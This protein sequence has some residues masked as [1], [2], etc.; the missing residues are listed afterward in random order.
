MNA[1][2]TPE[3]CRALRDLVNHRFVRFKPGMNLILGKDP[4]KRGVFKTVDLIADSKS[5]NQVPCE[6]L[7]SIQHLDNIDFIPDL[8]H[9]P[10]IDMIVEASFSGF[11]F[12]HYHC[13]VWDETGWRLIDD[14]SALTGV[15]P[16]KASALI[17]AM[18]I[19]PPF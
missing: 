14:K 5:D 7:N 10:T 6:Y 2:L 19:T 17:W 4:S 18:C 8:S 15:Y 9:Q 3:E 13:K 11:R 12:D 1:D 16:S